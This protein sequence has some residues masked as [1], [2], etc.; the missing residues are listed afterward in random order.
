MQSLEINNKTINKK[1]RRQEVKI[2]RINKRITS[3][4]SFTLIF[5]GDW[6]RAEIT[7]IRRWK[8][9]RKLGTE[10]IEDWR[11]EIQILE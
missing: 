8:K 5:L 2:F 10:K 3:I 7:D 6:G 1:C 9:L 11:I 4:M